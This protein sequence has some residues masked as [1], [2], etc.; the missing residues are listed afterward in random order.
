MERELYLK[1][2]YDL[3]DTRSARCDVEKILDVFLPSESID[4]V[5]IQN[6]LAS[7]SVLCCTNELMKN[8]WQMRPVPG[9]GLIYI[10]MSS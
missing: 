4:M 2:F 5:S 3:S 9:S 7:H 1:C 6:L 10:S 8:K